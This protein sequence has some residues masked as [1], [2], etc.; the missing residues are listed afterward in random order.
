MAEKIILI[1]G[2]DPAGIGYEIILKSFKK[3][4]LPTK[5]GF[6]VVLCNYSILSAY[7]QVL[8][9]GLKLERLSDNVKKKGLPEILKN[10]SLGK[11]GYI[12]VINI[13]AAYSETSAVISSIFYDR[14]VTPNR[15]ISGTLVI[16][17]LEMAV[18]LV[19]TYKDAAG[20]VTAPVNK[21]FVSKARAG[22]TGHTEFFADSFNVKEYSMILHS[23]KI[24]VIPATRHLPLRSISR[25]INYKIINRAVQDALSFTLKTKASTPRIAVLALNP[26]ASDNGIIGNEENQIIKP[27]LLSIKKQ[28]AKKAIAFEL[29][30][31]FSAD[32][33]FSKK[34]IG[35]YDVII[36]MYHDQVLIPFKMAAFGSGVN[37]TFGLP[38]VRTSVDHG[39]AYDIAGQ[40][41]ADENSFILAYKTAVSLC[42]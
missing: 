28:L 40:N 25:R 31:P 37:I 9:Y 41:K 26:H 35:Y 34:N 30:G 6:P 21:Y 22:F 12:P 38:V 36:G 32:T 3:S 33:F 13:G 24:T 39:T 1:T 7:N 19:K 14:R 29:D 2:G 23:K 10:L 4:A 27:A 15:S 11:P 16:K 18:S 20:I 17:T 42:G 8:K 5:S